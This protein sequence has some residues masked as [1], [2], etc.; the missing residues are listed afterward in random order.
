MT[1]PSL[2]FCIVHALPQ[3]P[4]WVSLSCVFTHMPLQ[5]VLLAP[6]QTL[7]QVP[8][9][10]ESVMRLTQTPLHTV[11]PLLGQRHMPIVHVVGA[12]HVVPQVPQLLLSVMRLTHA[13]LH[14]VSPVVGH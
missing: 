3:V 13:P 5:H 1:Q 11:S 6:L 12:L 8:Q 9:F 10:I 2:A 4:Q 7:P 14:T